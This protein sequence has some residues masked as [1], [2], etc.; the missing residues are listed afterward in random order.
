[1]EKEVL[2]KVNQYLESSLVRNKDKDLHQ[3]TVR[4]QCI[5]EMESQLLENFQYEDP[6]DLNIVSSLEFSTYLGT[7]NQRYENKNKKP[8]YSKPNQQGQKLKLPEHP[9]SKAKYSTQTE[10]AAYWDE[11]KNKPCFLH[12]AE[13][14]AHTLWECGMKGVTKME[15]FLGLN[16]CRK[17]GQPG[18]RENS[19]EARFVP[20]CEECN[21]TGHIKIFCNLWLKEKAKEYGNLRKEESEMWNTEQKSAKQETSNDPKIT[22][23]Q[24][25]PVGIC[26]EYKPTAMLIKKEENIPNPSDPVELT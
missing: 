12:A 26:R 6:I 1:M 20:V 19:C 11:I 16:R 3:P 4:V 23:Y 8:A 5:Q 13:K 10:I 2:G 15:V 7:Q 24:A 18:H 9:N 14:E 17:C 21:Q 22:E 25:K